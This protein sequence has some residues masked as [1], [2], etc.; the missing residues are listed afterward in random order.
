VNEVADL[1]G[2]TH[3][4]FFVPAVEDLQGVRIL[5][6]DRVLVEKNVP[7]EIADFPEDRQEITAQVSAGTLRLR[8]V[9]VGRSGAEIT[10]R[11][12][13]SQDGGNT[14]QVMALKLREPAFTM[15]I[16]P[17][18]DIQQSLFEIQASDGIHTSTITISTFGE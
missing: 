6:E 14:W 17:G 9:D 16:E 2:Y 3:F 18:I 11:L 8:W 4:G 13:I 1:N 10:Y 15:P 12:R 5:R 7:G